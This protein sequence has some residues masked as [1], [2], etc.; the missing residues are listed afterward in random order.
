MNKAGIAIEP[1]FDT[2]VSGPLQVKTKSLKIRTESRVAVQRI[3]DPI[4]ELIRLSG[5]RDGFANIQSS[6]T[7]VALFVNEYQDALMEDIKGFLERLIIRDGWYRHNSADFS[8]CER[9]NADAHL[10]SVL[11][12]GSVSLQIQAGRLQLGTWQDIL[13]AE[14]DGPQER[15]L[16]IQILGV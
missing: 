9:K 16:T 6:H 11:L 7:T 12:G 8:D 2:E 15:T 1:G 4:R 5:V 3:T 13:L 10:R 14:L